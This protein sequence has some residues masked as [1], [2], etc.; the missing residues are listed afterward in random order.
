MH[1]P[2]VS[3][4]TSVCKKE[5]VRVAISVHVILAVDPVIDTS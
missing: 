1:I 2:Y 3:K 4:S 5:I